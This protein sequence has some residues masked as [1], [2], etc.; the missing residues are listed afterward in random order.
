MRN[1]CAFILVAIL[2]TIQLGCAGSMKGVVRRDAKRIEVTYTDSRLGQA[3]LQTV[4]PGGERFEG[5][6][7][8]TGW[9]GAQSDSAVSGNDSTD[10]EDVQ[11]FEGNAEATL[12]GNK[13]NVMRCRFNL[14]DSIIGLSSGGF[15][16]CQVT[17]GRVID[18]FF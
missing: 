15:G 11:M 16:L 13:G 14:T 17:D 6:I 5:K 18:I 4:L 8:R 12:S 10:F 7:V 9:A 3:R 1:W 2:L